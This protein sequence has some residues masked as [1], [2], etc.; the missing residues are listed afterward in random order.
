MNVEDVF[1]IPLQTANFPNGTKIIFSLTLPRSSVTL[2]TDTWISVVQPENITISTLPSEYEWNEPSDGSNRLVVRNEMNFPFGKLVDNNWIF[3]YSGCTPED[4][5]NNTY[6]VVSYELPEEN[7]SF[8]NDEDLNVEIF[9]KSDPL[10]VL[11]FAK[12]TENSQP[13]VGLHSV[14]ATITN[15]ESQQTI[16]NVPLQDNGP[17]GVDVMSEDGV[18]SG[19]FVPTEDG[20]YVVTVTVSGHRA[21]RDFLVDHV[22]RDSAVQTF[23]PVDQKTVGCP[24][25]VASCGV[26]GLSKSVLQLT[27]YPE[28]INLEM[29]SNFE[30]R[31]P[32]SICLQYFGVVCM[33]HF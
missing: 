11:I 7:S 5:C 8:N 20:Q 28:V 6:V 13:V 12:I 4:A 33:S 3:Q 23:L 29:V 18:Y 25:T 27:V 21:N 31:S 19:Y 1:Q 16:F 17:N 30:V 9:I 14:E 2:P 22:H 10:T 32:Y 15:F 24:S 26:T